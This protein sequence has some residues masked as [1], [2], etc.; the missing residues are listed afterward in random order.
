MQIVKGI[1]VSPG[2]VIGRVFVQDDR[3]QRIAPRAIPPE[4]VPQELARLEDALAKSVADLTAVQQRSEQEM[5]SE[6]AKIFLF[7]IGVLQDP[8]LVGPMREIVADEMLC[9][10]YAVYH[11]FQE[12]AARFAAMRDTAITTKVDDLRD[13]AGRVLD[14]LIGEHAVRLRQLPH[15][16]VVL[17]SDLTPSQTADFDRE[18]VMAFATDLGG[19]TS[20]TAIVARALRI[21]AV[22]GCHDLTG[23]ATEGQRVIIDGDRGLVILDPDRDHLDRYRQLIEQART[24]QLSL[25]ELSILPC[26]TADGAPVCILGNI[27]FPDEIA[28]ILELGGE[29][30]GLYRT[31][32]LYLTRQ[33]EPTEEEHYEAYRKCVDLLAGRELTIRT[34][35]LGA[36]KYTQTQ[37]EAPERNPFLGLRSIRYSL[38]HLLDFKRQLRAILRASA[39]GPIRIMVPLV[40]STGELRQTRALLRDVMEDLSDEGVAFDPDIDVGMMVEVPAAA[41]MADTFAREA[42]FFSIGT[43]DLVQYTLAVD[44]TNERVAGLFTPFHP[45]VLRL[46]REVTRAGERRGT[47]VSCCGESAADLEFAILL[48]GLGLR[49]LSV[50]PPS[51]PQLRRLVRSVTIRQCERIARRAVALDSDSEVTAYVRDQ[52]R[53]IIPE[54]FEG[55]ALDE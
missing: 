48:L 34:V 22:V 40:T 18:L 26:E 32:F 23:R 33:S 9:A 42:D 35:D 54:A 27:E 7:H 51:I 15:Q 8:T 5:G 17:A 36:D 53:K 25:R 44:R 11:V 50:A 24:F 41:V 31:E 45:A 13:L 43:N 20:H 37:L 29:G 55:R 4:Q 46:I 10:E 14:H 38:N 49:T 16:A 52:A 3:T 2:I 19:R 12:W 39:D 30:V 1:P 21:P 6:A 47:P 28:S